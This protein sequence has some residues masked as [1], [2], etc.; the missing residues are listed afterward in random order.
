MTS[1]DDFVLQ[2]LQDKGIVNARAVAS[3][4]SQ[5]KPG[6]APDQEPTAILDALVAANN[7]STSQVFETLA[8]EFSMD[9][10][11]LSE[12]TPATDALQ[13]INRDLALRYKVFPMRLEGKQ[14]DLAVCDPLNMDAVDSLSKM[15]NLT[16]N[17]F[18]ASPKEID[19]AINQYYEVAAGS[20]YG[21]MFKGEMEAEK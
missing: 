3:A 10:A 20:Q 14:L 15:L 2:L 7:I 13:L 1:A 8:A 12:N 11:R 5:L 6:T 9:L 4:R 17:T 16:I 21:D 18:L 19:D